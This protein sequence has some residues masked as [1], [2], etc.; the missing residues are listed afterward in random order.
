[1]RKCL[2]A[3]MVMASMKV[4][5]ITVDE[6]ADTLKAHPVV[7]GHFTQLRLLRG[8]SKPIKSSG[9]YQLKVGDGLLWQLEKPF[10]I[11]LKITKDG[12]FQQQAD[13]SWQESQQT[14]S[15]QMQ[16]FLGLLSGDWQPLEH[17]F[18]MTASG[19]LQQ[20]QLVLTPKGDTLKQIFT[21]ITLDGGV[22]ISHIRIEEAQGD[23]SDI[24][25]FE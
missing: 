11:V 20:W 21:A 3:I 25:F 16:L 9:Q 18:E 7:Q 6:V 13:G 17:F 24:E 4:F 2:M 23:Q 22:N 1:M 12:I 8:M 5:A 15:Q 10:P 19:K 14:N